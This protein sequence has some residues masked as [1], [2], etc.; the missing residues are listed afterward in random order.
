MAGPRTAEAAAATWANI[1]I[2]V[3][4]VTASLAQ[5]SVSAAWL[6][7]VEVRASLSGSALLP[8]PVPP[9]P[10]PSAEERLPPLPPLP[11]VKW[12]LLSRERGGG[13]L[14][15]AVAAAAG[16]REA[17]APA[18]EGRASLPAFATDPRDGSL[19]LGDLR[20]GDRGLYLCEA[21]MGLEDLKRAVRLY[22]EGV[23]F[24]YRAPQGRYALNLRG[25]REACE[26][27]GG[28][29]ASP[30]Q[31]SAALHDGLHQCDAGWLNDGSVRYPVVVPRPGCY[32]DLRA[33]PG[34][35]SYGVRNPWE[36]YDAY[37]YT[38][39]N[40]G[41]V[42]YL[43]RAGT[44]PFP[45]A[46]LACAA[47]GASLAT[48]GQLYSAW[49][50]HGLDRCDAGW[51]ADGS[52]RYPITHPRDNCGGGEPGVRTLHRHPDQSGFP[53][54][55]THYGVYC[56]RENKASTSSP[57][58]H[59]NLDPSSTRGTQDPVYVTSLET[60]DSRGLHGPLE[61]S[62]P[63]TGVPA[64]TLGPGG[65][66]GDFKEATLG[67]GEPE[68]S[69]PA[70][71]ESLVVESEKKWH[72]TVEDAGLLQFSPMG[73]WDRPQADD[74]QS[75]NA[76]HHHHHNNNIEAAAPSSSSSGAGG[77]T[78]SGIGSRDRR[79]AETAL[80]GDVGSDGTSGDGSPE[81]SATRAIVSE[82]P[83]LAVPMPLPP[84]PPSDPI[85]RPQAQDDREETMAMTTTTTRN[86]A[87]VVADEA[88]P[89]G[90]AMATLSPAPRKEV[91]ESPMLILLESSWVNRVTGREGVMAGERES[92]WRKGVMAG[93]PVVE[94]GFILS[95]ISPHLSVMA[96]T[97]KAVQ[98]RME[99]PGTQW[100]QLT[101][102]Q[103]AHLEKGSLARPSQ[104][105]PLGQ[106]GVNPDMTAVNRGLDVI[107]PRPE[108]AVMI[109]SEGAT[110]LNVF[111]T[112][113]DNLLTSPIT[114][115]DVPPSVAEVVANGRE[116]R[117]D[118]E[119]HEKMAVEVKT[120]P[121]EEE[122]KEVIGE[123]GFLKATTTE[124]VEGSGEETTV[125]IAIA[126][127]GIQRG[128]AIVLPSYAES[129][130]PAE[131]AM[132][133]GSGWILGTLGE[134]A[135]EVVEH[136][137][138]MN[139]EVIGEVDLKDEAVDG[140]S[141]HPGEVTRTTS[142]PPTPPRVP[143]LT[144]PGATPSTMVGLQGL[145]EIST[146]GVGGALHSHHGGTHEEEGSADSLV[147]RLQGE[148]GA[149]MFP[150]LPDLRV[151]SSL[152]RAAPET[153]HPN[154]EE[155]KE[156]SGL[157]EGSGFSVDYALREDF[158]KNV[159]SVQF[160]TAVATATTT[161]TST[162]AP[163]EGHLS[164][165]GGIFGAEETLRLLPSSAL[166]D[167]AVNTG[168]LI[169]ERS[170]V[171]TE[172]GRETA[173]FSEESPPAYTVG[174]IQ[175]TPPSFRP[176]STKDFAQGY[177]PAGFPPK[178]I[179]ESLS[180]ATLNV[181]AASSQDSPPGHTT[182]PT[183]NSPLD[184]I[185]HFL[186][187]SSRY[188][189]SDSSPDSLADASRD[190]SSRGL[191]A[192]SRP[193]SHHHEHRESFEPLPEVLEHR[194]VQFSLG[195]FT[196]EHMGPGT[197]RGANI[198]LKG[199]NLN[200]VKVGGRLE[201]G[202]RAT[203]E[204]PTPPPSLSSPASPT[205]SPT[206]PHGA[207][208]EPGSGHLE[209][210]LGMAGPAPHTSWTP[211]HTYISTGTPG[212][213]SPGLVSPEVQP[214]VSVPPAFKSPGSTSPEMQSSVSTSPGLESPEFSSPKF[215][216][217]K[218]VPLGSVSLELTG[219]DT[220][221]VGVVTG[222]GA[223]VTGMTVVAAVSCEPGWHGFGGRCYR[224]VA[225]RL[226]WA[227][228]EEAC[229][230]VGGHLASVASRDENNFILALGSDYQWIG[231]NDRSSEG[232]FRWSDGSQLSFEHWRPQQPDSFFSSGEDCVVLIWHEEGE[233]ND[234][235]CSYR[236]P[237]CCETRP[238]RPLASR[239]PLR[240][241]AASRPPPAAGLVWCGH[242]PIVSNARCSGAPH[243]RY[244]VGASVRY[245]CR[246][247][248]LQRHANPTSRCRPDGSWER[249]RVACVPRPATRPGQ[250]KRPVWFG[251]Y[252]D[253]WLPAR[254]SR[255][256]HH[257][258]DPHNLHDPHRPHNL[259]HDPH[260]ARSLHG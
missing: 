131:T 8:C 118:K 66:G 72:V 78:A 226:P 101:G 192:D 179:L 46:V 15:A 157:A 193:D 117:G 156:P 3:V 100:R 242:P 29:L 44:L 43:E 24:H 178:F 16:S 21:M 102:T 165:L 169:A 211:G 120:D 41:E 116:G 173:R 79:I 172:P 108:E 145:E 34:V 115:N 236:L 176:E 77:P 245:R 40:Q 48:V 260:T 258:Q 203:T 125:I 76:S 128:P 20:D 10:P 132:I 243:G 168:D 188:S 221:H 133:E 74:D 106:Q 246:A 224:Y 177:T 222:E 84:S 137:N 174:F 56:Y 42:Y 158:D 31:L 9:L 255:W 93:E 52:V 220:K 82:T 238:G 249:P 26:R 35:R 187:D 17:V 229:R 95:V 37:C 163:A 13:P 110:S 183:L 166:V 55:E 61:G 32:G 141:H 204:A 143:P 113:T 90:P 51:L 28:V 19:A 71:S 199:E 207:G 210:G 171:R 223:T 105:P 150:Q 107:V 184:F 154:G 159:S 164:R 225:D 194:Q 136:E 6:P 83:I 252:K 253:A 256:L 167:G 38:G 209:E 96:G 130:S 53:E 175:D 234:V 69:G 208:L 87:R 257:L 104:K 219:T 233:W 64:T 259:P 126:T 227:E 7:V 112:Q 161:A 63:R 149:G 27:A 228:A 70:A 30:L 138:V 213:E 111:P 73:G 114:T 86:V 25:A 142:S 147:G 45:A 89:D 98:T 60:G 47:A 248:F 81:G 92:P 67:V 94:G 4:V 153:S 127:E 11:R 33:G 241:P 62:G 68:D 50:H 22:V 205:E 1:F 144:A 99:P 139:E 190:T 189:P 109:L 97:T 212:P 91:T 14:P 119:V 39:D 146:L 202:S 206:A 240:L 85:G 239:T 155:E 140:T 191:T 134:L 122:E 80:G 185:P 237:F 23:V 250:E 244:A 215:Q 198:D 103:P 251:L 201:G 5:R 49:H 181:P 148:E 218:T 254:A 54:P 2:L 170:S 186:L 216:S 121:A 57:S 58:V 160:S 152:S 151:P 195:D 230:S 197:L 18:Y 124:D 12:T 162:A 180:G 65:R 217:S 123:A 182:D 196:T 235:P 75:R 200:L 247:G 135:D 59:S 36:T 231:L 129:L 214:P 232:D 88:G